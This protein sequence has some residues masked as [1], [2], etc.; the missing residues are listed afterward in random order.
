M[1]GERLLDPDL[2]ENSEIQEIEGLGL[3]PSV[4]AF[5]VG[6]NARN[7]LQKRS[8]QLKSFLNFK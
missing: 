7:Y 8:R 6:E 1:L 3:L 5:G 4:T 2:K